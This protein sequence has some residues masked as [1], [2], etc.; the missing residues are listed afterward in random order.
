MPPS[1]WNEAFGNRNVKNFADNQ[2]VLACLKNSEACRM[3]TGSVTT[4][5]CGPF[6]KGATELI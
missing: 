3:T 5:V 6:R 4:V 1:I 2:V